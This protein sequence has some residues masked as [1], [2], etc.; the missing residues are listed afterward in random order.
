MTP[1]QARGTLPAVSRWKDYKPKKRHQGTYQQPRLRDFE[2]PVPQSLRRSSAG[3]SPTSRV[4][5]RKCNHPPIGKTR[6]SHESKPLTNPDG[7]I[8]GR[9]AVTNPPGKKKNRWSE[10][11]KPNLDRKKIWPCRAVPCRAVPCRAVPCLKKIWGTT[12]NRG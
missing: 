2:C 6:L 11:K 5:A 1:L 12:N 10:K 4:V 7:E 8:G 9:R 3:C